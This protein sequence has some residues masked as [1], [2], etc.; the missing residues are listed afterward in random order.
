M[1]SPRA[2]R[3]LSGGEGVVVKEGV[4]FEWGLVVRRRREKVETAR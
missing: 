4:M 1:D 3:L 2:L